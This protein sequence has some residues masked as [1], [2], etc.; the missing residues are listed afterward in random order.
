MT[1]SWPYATGDLITFAAENIPFPMT[2]RVKKVPIETSGKPIVIEFTDGTVHPWH[3]F[4]VLRPANDFEIEE[5]E[6]HEA[7]VAAANSDE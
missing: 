2:K 4:D 3:V 7:N 1:V 5:F 6:E